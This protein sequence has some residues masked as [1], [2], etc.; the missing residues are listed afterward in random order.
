MD[1]DELPSR[2]DL[3]LY[4]QALRNDWPMPPAVKKR[5]LQLAVNLCEPDDD[6]AQDAG[7]DD[8]EEGEGGGGDQHPGWRRQVR[9]M[10]IVVQ[11]SR[12]NLGQQSVDLRR[13]EHE[14][15]KSRDKRLSPPAE[16]DAASKPRLIIPRD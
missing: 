2:S 5:I 8:A 12:L 7:N 16:S 10:A 3:A 15:L 13:A 4:E 11:F 1:A 6:A 14:R 9:A